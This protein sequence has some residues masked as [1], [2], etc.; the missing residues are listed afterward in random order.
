M[1]Y[2]GFKLE[3]FFKFL[4]RIVYNFL[5]SKQSFF[6]SLINNSTYTNHCIIYTQIHLHT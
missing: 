2:S 6:A 3:S 5:D 4:Y 1:T